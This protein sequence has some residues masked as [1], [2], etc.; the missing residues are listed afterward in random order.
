LI[1]VKRWLLLHTSKP[2]SQKKYIA[3]AFAHQP[4]II[5]YFGMMFWVSFGILVFCGLLRENYGLNVKDAKKL[6][7]CIF[8]KWDRMHY[9]YTRAL[10]RSSLA[11]ARLSAPVPRHK[12]AMP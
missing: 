5:L 4:Q 11:R 12:Q 3:G 8:W 2:E 10:L 7:N 6:K 1:R 9:H